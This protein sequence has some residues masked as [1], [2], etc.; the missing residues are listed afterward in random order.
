[1]WGV[2]VWRACI[3]A[4]IGVQVPGQRTMQHTWACLSGA[5]HAGRNPRQH[6]PPKAIQ[7]ARPQ[8]SPFSGMRCPVGRGHGWDSR[9]LTMARLL[10]GHRTSRDACHAAPRQQ[11]ARRSV[12]QRLRGRGV[13]GG[14]RL[15]GR[16]LADKQP[17]RCL[18]LCSQDGGLPSAVQ[19]T[20]GRG[21]K[22]V[23]KVLRVIF[24][25]SR[26]GIMS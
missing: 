23:S 5:T 8:H 11:Q 25:R 9:G 20:R 2:G 19:G 22:I 18:A 6:W 24:G 4:Q 21:M 12:R 10:Q 7:L 16:A 15:S 14:R 3:R 13:C 1:M 26:G 17:R